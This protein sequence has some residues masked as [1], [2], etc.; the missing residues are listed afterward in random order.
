MAIGAGTSFAPYAPGIFERCLQI[1]QK[2]LLEFQ[3]WSQNPDGGD[4]PDSSFVV[5][6]L[7][8]LSG[9][10]QGLGLNIVDLVNNSGNS[11]LQ[12]MSS[13]LHVSGHGA[14]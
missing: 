6:A 3:T 7:D 10:C 14:G 4:E 2:E 5:V 12:L 8:L 13:C 11:I 9:L 1:I